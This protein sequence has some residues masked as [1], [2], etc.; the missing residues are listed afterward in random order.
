MT[1]VPTDHREMISVA[2]RDGVRL[3]IRYAPPHSPVVERTVLPRDWT[4]G[5]EF[6]AWDYEFGAYRT[7]DAHFVTACR[8]VI[9][10][11]SLPERSAMRT[12]RVR[13]PG[14][15][16]SL[17][18]PLLTS[19][20]SSARQRFPRRVGILIGVCTVIFCIIC[21]RLWWGSG[22]AIDP[23]QRIF[24]TPTV[25]PTPTGTPEP[26]A[27]ST[28][29]SRRMLDATATAAE[30][31]RQATE[32]APCHP[33]NGR[34]FAVAGRTV[35]MAVPPDARLLVYASPELDPAAARAAM[36]HHIRAVEGRDATGEWLL[37]RMTDGEAFWVQ[38]AAVGVHDA[39]DVVPQWQPNAE[40]ARPNVPR[41]K[42]PTPRP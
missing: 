16:G 32:E 29:D 2:M 15:G 37:L 27:T 21:A 9:D 23:W 7:F 12:S 40:T 28:I 14:Q 38:A 41:R 42:T 3:S 1:D 24:G 39:F 26:T 33:R 17:P 34:C 20:S 35:V 4:R 30:V 11:S 10:D 6:F 13:S 8:R 31:H 22:D 5:A 25:L 19:R 36:R 18:P